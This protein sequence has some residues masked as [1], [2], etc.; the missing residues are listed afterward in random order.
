M[1]WKQLLQ[2]WCVFLP[3]RGAV[4][5]CPPDGTSAYLV[6]NVGQG[7]REPACRDAGASEAATGGRSPERGF[8]GIQFGSSI[9][10]AC[11]AFPLPRLRRIL[12][13][14]TVT[15]A[16]APA[17]CPLMCATRVLLVKVWPLRRL[18]RPKVPHPQRTS[19]T[20]H[21]GLAI[22]TKLRSSTCH[23]CNK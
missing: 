5:S 22:P 23:A 16:W 6:A 9:P 11:L 3:L 18:N 10:V 2:I 4:P 12:V 1:E 17:R 19:R 20:T 7:R 14:D 8:P 13:F 21:G 15:E